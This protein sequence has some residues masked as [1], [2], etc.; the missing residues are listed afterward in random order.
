[1]FNKENSSEKSS[2]GSLINHTFEELEHV[3]KWQNFLSVQAR[4]HGSFQFE[5]HTLKLE[6]IDL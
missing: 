1:M 3:K 6:T 4:H 5:V 2:F